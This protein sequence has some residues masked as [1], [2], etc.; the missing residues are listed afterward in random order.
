MAARKLVCPAEEL[1]ELEVVEKKI[2]AVACPRL[3]TPKSFL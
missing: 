1:I 3:T 2:M